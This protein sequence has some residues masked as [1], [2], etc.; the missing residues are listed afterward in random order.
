MSRIDVMMEDDI[1]GFNTQD[2]FLA[3]DREHLLQCC[4]KYALEYVDDG[5]DKIASKYTHDAQIISQMKQY[6][7]FA[8]EKIIRHKGISA[9][10]SVAH[11]RSWTWL[12]GDDEKNYPQYGAPIIQRVANVFEVELPHNEV[13]QAMA[14]GKVC[15]LCQKD[16]MGCNE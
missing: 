5:L 14:Q 12:I 10:R 6:L 1:L 16:P 15:P 11:Y 8:V 3:L 4:S 9:S 7:G 13:F 2:L